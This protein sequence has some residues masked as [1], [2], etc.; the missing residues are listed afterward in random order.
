MHRSKW[1]PGKPRIRSL[2]LEVQE[3]PP[4]H[5]FTTTSYHHLAIS[6][7]LLK[8]N[9]AGEEQEMKSP[10]QVKREKYFMRLRSNFSS[11]GEAAELSRKHICWLKPSWVDYSIHFHFIKIVH[12]WFPLLLLLSPLLAGRKNVSWGKLL[13]CLLMT[14]KWSSCAPDSLYLITVSS[15]VR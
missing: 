3:A 15:D 1:I 5:A 6:T 4:L 8:Q 11:S 13:C 7:R 14:W 9:S 2:H 10:R 12:L